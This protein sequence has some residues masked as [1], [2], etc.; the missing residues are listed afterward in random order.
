M[1]FVHS[2]SES[3]LDKKKN[4]NAKLW[5]CALVSITSLNYSLSIPGVVLMF[6]FFARP[7]K[8]SLNRF[9]ISF[10]LILC[11]IAS[12]ISVLEKVRKRLPASGLMQSSFITLY[13]MYLTWSAM[14]N[15]PEK[16]C[17]PGLLNLF[18]QDLALNSSSTNRTLVERPE[19]PYFLA[20]DTQS[21]VGLLMFVLCI[22]FS[23]IRSSST[24]Q[25]NKFLLTPSNPETMDYSTGSLH[26]PEGP[27]R[28]I[29]NER[30]GIQYS[31]SFFHMQLFLASLYIM[32]TLTNW[33][34]KIL[35]W[36]S[37][38]SPLRSELFTSFSFNNIFI[39]F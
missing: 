24:S 2:L 5:G 23:S 3:W 13:T 35:V 34:I 18:Q 7:E 8:C 15:E 4:Q 19:H 11:I 21:I 31:Y 20:E 12:V 10:N 37:V 28:V 25:V 16:S 39:D 33:Y 22:L 38:V 30:D 32:M 6:M 9:F 27:R 14:T 36:Y 29:D 17:N 1:D 26:E